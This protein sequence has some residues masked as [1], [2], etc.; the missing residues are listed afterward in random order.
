MM[1]VIEYVEQLV[2]ALSEQHH[3]AMLG[4]PRDGQIYPRDGVDLVMEG[5]EYC[6]RAVTNERHTEHGYVWM[7][8]GQIAFDPEIAASAFRAVRQEWIRAVVTAWLVSASTSVR[9]TDRPTDRPS[10][11]REQ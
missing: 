10:T 1:S 6:L 5:G 11:T 4:G 8:H 7:G 3:Y 9:P 2:T